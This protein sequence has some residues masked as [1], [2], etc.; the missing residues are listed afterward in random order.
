MDTA[1][2]RGY[3]NDG[4]DVRRAIDADHIHAI[5]T[6]IG[7]RMLRGGKLILMGNGGSAAD[8]QHIAAE[9]MGRFERERR[10]LPALALHTNTSTLT[11]IANDYGYENV[12]KRQIE[13]LAQPGDIVIGISTSGNSPNVVAA[14]VSARAIGCMTVAMV[15]KNGGKMAERAEYSIRVDSGRTSIIQ[16]CHIAVGHIMSKVVEDML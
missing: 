8:A 15:G 6:T 10:P 13:A 4:A 5:S 9:F 2:V 14:L 16:E 3:L 11:A 12:F 7:Q 1:A